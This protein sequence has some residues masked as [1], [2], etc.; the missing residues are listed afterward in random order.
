M[1]RYE[2]PTSDGLEAIVGWDPPM[3]TFF[4]QVW[5]RTKDEDDPDAELL[6]VGCTPRE[7]NDIQQVMD[8]VKPW[9]KIPDATK[10]A[11]CRDAA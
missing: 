11:L 10:R 4:A 3:S 2:L 5:D 6:W 7:M 9:A 8:A 1:S